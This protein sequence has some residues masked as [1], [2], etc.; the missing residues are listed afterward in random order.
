MTEDR[1]R[2]VF[3]TRYLKK[4]TLIAV[5]TA[6]VEALDH[7]ASDAA[8]TALVDKCDRVAKLKGA[9]ALRMSYLY[10][11]T[12][13]SKIPPLDIFVQNDYKKY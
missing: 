12:P 10:D 11:G 1:G 6:V 9:E 4:G 7:A 13:N 8:K 5:E 3:A 2:G